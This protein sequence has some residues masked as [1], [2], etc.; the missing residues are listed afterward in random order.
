VR[1]EALEHFEAAQ[2]EGMLE[3]AAERTPAGRILTPE[4]VAGL[5]AFLCS[6]AAYM[7]RGQTIL[8]DGGYTLPMDTNPSAD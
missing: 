1:T 3:R 5:V 2:E 6:P 8:M 7:I 4:D